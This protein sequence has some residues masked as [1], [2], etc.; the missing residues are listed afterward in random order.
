MAEEFTMPKL[1]LTMTD[2]TIREWLV[3]D[4]AFV[5][6]GEPILVIETDKVETEVEARADGVLRLTGVVGSTYACGDVIG[7]LVD[8]ATGT[9]DGARDPAE[10]QLDLFDDPVDGLVDDGVDG[11]ERVAVEALDNKS[12]S[13]LDAAIAAADGL[14]VPEADPMWAGNDPGLDPHLSDEA[15]AAG[16]D[17]PDGPDAM[18]PA[19]LVQAPVVQ[20]DEV[21]EIASRGVG[22]RILASPRARAA[23]QA[24]DLDLAT[25]AGTGPGGRIVY[26]DVVAAIDS[27]EAARLEAERQEAERQEAERQEAERLEAERQEAERLEA[28]REESERR[29]QERLAA[30]PPPP[31]E[32]TF[33]QLVDEPEPAEPLELTDTSNVRPLTLAASKAQGDLP[34]LAPPETNQPVH[35]TGGARLLADFLGIDLAAVGAASGGRITREDVGA[36]V[37]ERLALLDG[38]SAPAPEPTPV[39]SLSLVDTDPHAYAPLLQEPVEII[40]L[41]GMRG[42]IASR[43]Q[44]SLT[45]MAQLTLS[46][47]VD[48]SGIN[49]ERERRRSQGQQVPGYTAWVV[50]AAA[51]A[52]E[53]HGYINSQITAEGIA[54]LP[55]V[56]VG[57]AVALDEGLIVPVIEH[58]NLRTVEETHAVVADLAGRARVGKLKFEELE[59]A[60]FSVT[61]LGMFGV[62]MFTPVIN[63]PNTA[64]LGVGRLRSETAWNDGRPEE[65]VVMTL[66]LTWDHR[67]FDGAPAAEFAQTIVRLLQ[68]PTELV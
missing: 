14:L 60:T 51:Q 62:D 56:H 37:R 38:P 15:V 65:K 48:M 24:G 42:L 67:A 68:E 11:R 26:D 31:A 45:D 40:P 57:V 53:L 16:L 23:A 2:G 61:A 30:L 10:P 52:I 21:V 1:G 43:M 13:P 29:E 49:T 18:A 33:A 41:Q 63:P 25:I 4:G 66:S 47:D 6:A 59:G 3:E 27:V 58:A 5:R 8:D 12:L 55:D 46:V 32:P 17:G 39:R 20:V 54:L 44:S 22:G 50:A 19:P 28:E 7:Y 34:D 36:W 64:I 35:A 9:D